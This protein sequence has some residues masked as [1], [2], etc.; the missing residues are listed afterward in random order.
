[1]KAYTYKGYTF[2]ATN[3]MTTIYVSDGHGGHNSRTVPLYE[4]DDLKERGKRPFLTSI[5]Q[6][7]EYINDHEKQG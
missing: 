1:M 3:T 2:R 4:I 6:C 7:K 5:D